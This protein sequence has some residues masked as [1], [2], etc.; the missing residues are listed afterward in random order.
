MTT[1]EQALKRRV[2]YLEAQ[3]EVL[4]AIVEHIESV[5]NAF[6]FD[7]GLRNP[8]AQAPVLTVERVKP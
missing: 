3:V 6:A 8:E 7:L 1:T 4:V 5:A 2:R